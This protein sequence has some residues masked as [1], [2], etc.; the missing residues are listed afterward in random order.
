MF[1]K[2]FGDDKQVQRWMY[3]LKMNGEILG[4]EKKNV[5]WF[6]TQLRFRMTYKTNKKKNM[7]QA[8]IDV[9]TVG[10]HCVIIEYIEFTMIIGNGK[11]C[12]QI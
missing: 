9:R 12:Q 4:R 7:P 8:L 11:R 5:T 10:F 6:L 3:K 2:N 1:E